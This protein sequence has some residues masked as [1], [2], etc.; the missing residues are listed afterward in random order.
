MISLIG[1]SGCL[2]FS[3]NETSNKNMRLGNRNGRMMGINFIRL[4]YYPFYM[5]Y[6]WHLTLSFPNA[7]VPPVVMT[8]PFNSRISFSTFLVLNNQRR[9]LEPMTVLQ[10]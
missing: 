7:Y 2:R 4:V 3:G 6:H 10:R 8:L 9:I 5:K 1:L